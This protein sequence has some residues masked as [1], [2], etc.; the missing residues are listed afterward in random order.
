MRAFGTPWRASRGAAP[1]PVATASYPAG[2]SRAP[3]DGRVRKSLRAWRKADDGA[4]LV[5][6]AII[7]MPF[8]LF[9]I[10][11]FQ[12]G[13]VFFEQA[14]FQSAVSDAG[15]L[16]LTGQAT[17][18]AYTQAQFKQAVCNELPIF[19]SCSNVTID[20]RPY[21]SFSAATIYKPVD[22]NGN[23]NPSGAGYSIG[24]AKTI[25]VVSAYAA[26]PVLFP[27]MNRFMSNIGNGQILI[28]ASATF[29]NEPWSS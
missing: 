4:T 23:Y 12:V 20:V 11:I 8:F 14:I 28:S 25:V 17:T 3:R 10:A 24:G 29:R 18:G 16:I 9:V 27:M 13:L 21:A 6:F 26:Q 7:S 5:E 22:A 15:R 1:D 2:P 19:I